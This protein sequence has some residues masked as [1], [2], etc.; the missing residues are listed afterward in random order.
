[1]WKLP[2][3]KPSEDYPKTKIAEIDKLFAENAKLKARED[4]YNKMIADGDK[5]FGEKSYEGAKGLFTQA[6]QLKT[7]EKYPK[8]RSL[9]LIRS[10]LIL[11]VRKALDDKYKGIIANADKLLVAKTLR[12][13]PDRVFQCRCQSNRQEQY[14]QRQDRRDR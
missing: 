13:G 1:M 4:Q 10:L 8:I 2:G 3:L 12:S 14:P 11:P 5:L 6:S 9:R 7:E